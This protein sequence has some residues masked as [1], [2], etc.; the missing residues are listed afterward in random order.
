MKTVWAVIFFLAAG[1]AFA[2]AKTWRWQSA[3]GI[4]HYSDMPPPPG[5]RNIQEI[6]PSGNVI[7][8]DAMSYTARKAAADHPVTLFTAPS[9]VEEC[10]SAREYLGS[11]GIPYTEL[12]MTKEEDH[13]GYRKVFGSE[14]AMVPSITVG[15]T[16]KA[17]GFER[18]Q[19]KK[20]LDLA[21]YPGIGGRAPTPSASG[22]KP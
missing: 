6:S 5:A 2:Q 19:W 3:D 7:D 16:Q 22:A 14:D 13:A 8:N 1:A 17:R 18:G 10:K 20:M 11:R 15:N 21:G 9:C 4:I 12:L